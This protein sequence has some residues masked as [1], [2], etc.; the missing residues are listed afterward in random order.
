[1]N[2]ILSFNEYNGQELEVIA[3]ENVLNEKNSM[4]NGIKGFLNRRASMKV[5]SELE[6]EIEMS[7]EIMEGIK[8]GLESISDNFDA[9]QKSLDN[10]DNDKKKGKKQ[11][12]LDDITKILDNSKKSTWDLNELIDE[13]EIDYTGFTA[14]VAISSVAYFGILLTP[15]RATMMIHKGY[16]YFFN[17]VKNTIRKALV[18][19][20]LNFDQ[21]S[22]LIVTQSMRAAGVITATDTSND[23]GEFYGNIM[24][25]ISENKS[26]GKKQ[27]DKVKKLLDAAKA[28][29]DQQVKADKMKDNAENMFNNLDPYNNTYTESLKALR[30]YASEDVQKQLDSIKAAMNKLA[31][32][33][34]DLQAYAELLIAAAE[35][36]AYEVSTSIYNK[37]AKMTEVFSLPNQQKLIDL[38]LAANKEE[39]KEAKK[40]KNEREK[41]KELQA[42][43]KKEESGIEIFKSIGGVDIGKADNETH[44]YDE[45]EIKGAEKWTYD[46]FMKLNEK[47]RGTLESWLDPKTHPEVLKMCDETLQIYINTPF[48]DSS[49]IDSL[50][51]YIEPCIVADILTNESS[52]VLSYYEYICEKKG[53]K[54]GGK[55]D[56]KKGGMKTKSDSTPV[57]KDEDVSETD[58]KSY[59]LSDGEKEELNDGIDVVNIKLTDLFK[60]TLGSDYKEKDE[61]TD[62]DKVRL[63]YVIKKLKEEDAD[64]MIVSTMEDYKDA[65]ESRRTFFLDFKKLDK[66]QIDDLKELYENEDV[67]IV[68]LKAIGDKVLNDG[69]FSKN[70][71]YFVNRIKRCFE[72]KKT[73]LSVMAYLLLQRSISILDDKRDHDYVDVDDNTKE[74]EG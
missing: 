7:K 27:Y 48:G 65:M 54:K 39:K 61:L 16:K 68:A 57:S 53:G 24:A 30:Q 43:E 11:K 19:L 44:R 74:S 21:F 66:S 22:N 2:N 52:N 15:F 33:D 31:G 5:R 56:G 26:L 69:S 13:G 23:I 71:K 17:I 32:Q 34:A 36:H 8:N 63:N 49:Y 18:M 58:E 28:K 1:M 62:K 10:T 46:E 60:L 70:S 12:L 35:E 38:I 6:D 9:I 37:F 14:N 72:K 55:K 20:Q 3:Y 64:E 47:D 51:D 45:S 59:E 29:F 41:A 73:G 67:A 40:L 25:Q 50:V 42:A 4:G